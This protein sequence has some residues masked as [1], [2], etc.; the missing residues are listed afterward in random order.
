MRAVLA[1]QKEFGSIPFSLDIWKNLRRI[2]AHLLLGAEQRVLEAS[3]ARLFLLGWVAGPVFP[4]SRY[5]SVIIWHVL[6]PEHI[7]HDLSIQP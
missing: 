1:S 5:Y 2:G 7:S 3:G 4:L 6:S